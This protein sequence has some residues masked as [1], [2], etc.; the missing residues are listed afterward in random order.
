MSYIK[1]KKYYGQH[2]LTDQS[3]AERIVNSLNPSL[4]YILEIGPGKGVLTQY[5]VKK[6]NLYVIEID[7]ECAHHI[8]LNY[9]EL[10]DRLFTEDFLKFD[11]EKIPSSQF[12]IIGNF[13][14][15]ISSQIFFKILENKDQVIEV[16]CMLQK[17]VAQRIVSPPGNRDYGILSVLLQSYFNIEYLFTVKPGSFF[18]PPKVY[19]GVIRLTRNENIKLDCDD[20]LFFKVVKTSFNQRRKKLRNS[21]L[22]LTKNPISQEIFSKRPEQLHYT[23]FINITNLISTLSK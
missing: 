20:K 3:I 4:N 18:P 15:N 9:P 12:A 11:F 19:S 13:P 5:L 21:L 17:E 22:S 23:D 10:N 7:E 8:K 1:P 14:Y 2:F 16:V 6:D